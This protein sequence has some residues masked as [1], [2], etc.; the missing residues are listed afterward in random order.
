MAKMFYTMEET[1]A[2]LGRD[3]DGIKQ[4]AREGRLREFRDGARLMFKAD[5]VE[6]LKAELAG[7]AVEPIS[8]GGADSGAPIGLVGDSGT[9]MAPSPG[10]TG[11]IP[12]PGSGSGLLNLGSGTGSGGSRGGIS[13]FE[14]DDSQKV[15]PSAQTAI[16]PNIQVPANIEAGSGSGLLDLTREADDTSL[17]AVFD[18]LTPAA[19]RRPAPPAAAEARAAAPAPERA[20]PVT[21]PVAAPAPPD[22]LTG[23]LSGAALAAA[24]AVCFGGF[25]LTTAVLGYRP[26]ILASIR[27]SGLVY[28]GLMFGLTLL[29]FAVGYFMSSK[30]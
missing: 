12:S 15:D 29:F 11:S 18:E 16:N 21:A 8:L 25:V 24:I 4:L 20:R 27:D 28:L 5:Q 26:Q 9:A 22:A 1:K 6:Q 23:A 17:G 13:V 30:K 3:E 19:G 7:G 10:D 2:A 14:V